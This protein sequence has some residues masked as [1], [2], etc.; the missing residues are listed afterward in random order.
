MLVLYF[1]F[2]FFKQPITIANIIVIKQKT[3]NR[4][5]FSTFLLIFN[6]NYH[7]EKYKHKKEICEISKNIC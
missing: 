2:L 4:K 5:Q 6:S 7:H 3:E 1:S